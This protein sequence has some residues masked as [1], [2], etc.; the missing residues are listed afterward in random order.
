LACVGIVHGDGDDHVRKL[1]QSWKSP[2][3]SGRVEDVST[4][5]GVSFDSSNMSPAGVLCVSNSVRKDWKAFALVG[6][7][8]EVV[9]EE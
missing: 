1:I 2:M 8:S 7:L 9:A 6:Q 5:K 4:K 3:F